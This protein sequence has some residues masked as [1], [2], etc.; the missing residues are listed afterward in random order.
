MRECR[1]PS[2]ESESR[3]EE[4]VNINRH[5]NVVARI[6]VM[7]WVETRGWE[8][9]FDWI[10]R[11]TC[12]TNPPWRLGTKQE[13][14]RTDEGISQ[15]SSQ[16]TSSIEYVH[17]NFLR[18]DLWTRLIP[19]RPSWPQVPQSLGSVLPPSVDQCFGFSVYHRGVYTQKREVLPDLPLGCVS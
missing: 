15:V 1:E 5:I 6:R 11:E 18:C 19:L 14:F 8:P 9:T 7:R 10:G 16:Q 2:G 17:V 12:A 4:M 3:E 13:P